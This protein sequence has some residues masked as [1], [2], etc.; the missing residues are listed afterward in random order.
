MVRCSIFCDWLT[1][2]QVHH[3]TLPLVN[4][5]EV[6]AVNSDGEIEW[7]TQKK[8]VHKGSYDSKILISCDGNRVYLSGNVGRFDRSNNVFGYSV[9]ECVAI[10]NSILEKVGLPPFTTGKAIPVRSLKFNERQHSLSLDSYDLRKGSVVVNLKGFEVDNDSG[11]IQTGAV[12]TRVDLTCNY[13]SGSPQNA[14]NVINKLSGFK[15]GKFDPRHYGSNGVAWGIDH[16]NKGSKYW[17]RKVYDKAS[18]YFRQHTKGTKFFEQDLA[19][20][21][22]HN[23]ILRDEITLKSRYLLQN[24]LNT[25]SRWLEANMES[26]VFALFDSPFDHTTAKVDEFLEIEGRAGELAV[27]WRDGADLKK[28]LATR[29]FYRYRKELLKYGIDIAIPSKVTRLKTSVEVIELHPAS[30]PAFYSL[31]SLEERKIAAAA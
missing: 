12:I 21:L 9:A 4:D 18:D 7:K 6:F 8:L 31:P 5:G 23:G 17:V 13:T 28:R 11:F 16:E 10:A 3:K 26:K 2:Y 20:Y 24:N 29:T 25:L 19:E 14:S 22:L 30:I 1:I 27:A 15:L